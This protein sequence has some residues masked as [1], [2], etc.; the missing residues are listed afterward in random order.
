MEESCRKY[1]SEAS[2]RLPFNFGK[3][4]KTAKKNQK[5]YIEIG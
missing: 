5:R 4:P 1:A 2:P 3:K